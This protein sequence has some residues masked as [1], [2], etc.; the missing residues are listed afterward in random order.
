[1][2]RFAPNPDAFDEFARQWFH[3][4]VLPEYRLHEPRK[5]REGDHWKVSVRLENAGTGT[6]PVEVAAKR[7]VRFDKTGQLSAEYREA[8]AIATVGKGQSQE[9]TTT[10]PFEPESII[11]D[12]DAKVLQLQRNSAFVKF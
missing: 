7:G 3:E 12:P 8:R 4:V 6:M 5:T 1:M 9:L 2:R 10:C 11:I